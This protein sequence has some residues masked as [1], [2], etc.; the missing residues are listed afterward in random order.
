MRDHIEVKNYLSK[1]LGNDIR[2]LETSSRLLAS[3]LQMFTQMGQE[4]ISWN[5]L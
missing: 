3:G 5:F 4:A 1:K 2:I